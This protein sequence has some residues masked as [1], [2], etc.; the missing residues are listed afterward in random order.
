MR[1]STLMTGLMIILIV[2]AAVAQE[3]W[4]ARD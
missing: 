3:V 4:R 2:G 1:C